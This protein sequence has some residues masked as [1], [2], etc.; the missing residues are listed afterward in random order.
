MASAANDQKLDFEIQLTP[1]QSASPKL[2]FIR[3]GSGVVYH[4]AAGSETESQNKDEGLSSDVIAAIAIVMLAVG[5]LL[6]IL[7]T[8]GILYVVRCMRTKSI[9]LQ[10][11]KTSAVSYEKQKDDIVTMQ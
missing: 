11:G 4:P 10:L 1:D 7:G 8:L 9:D 5:V 3:T 2:L 6:G